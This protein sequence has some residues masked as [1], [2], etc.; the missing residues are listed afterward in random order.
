M[1]NLHPIARSILEGLLAAAVVGCSPGPAFAPVSGVVTLN[2]KAKEGLIVTFQPIGSLENPEPGR[3]SYGH[4]DEQG[5][6]SL[7]SDDG[8]VGAVIGN[9]RVRIITPWNESAG[10][11]D[12]EIGSPDGD[13]NVVAKIEFDPIP[14]EWNAESDKTFE[15]TTTGTDQANFNIVS[16]RR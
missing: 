16:N 9:H 14:S 5:R 7:A 12:P 13:V 10:G 11:F 15:V 1:A 4:T 6:F 3:G 8:K 2:G